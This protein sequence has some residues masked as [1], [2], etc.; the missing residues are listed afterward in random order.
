MDF[1]TALTYR[2]ACKVFDNTK[3]IDEALLDEIIE[4]GR[5]A[6]SSMG[7]QPWKFL[8]I[9][10]NELRSKLKKACWDQSQITDC[11]SLVVILARTTSL[12][13]NSEYTN[14]IIS[15]RFDKNKSEQ[16]AYRLRYSNF[17]ENNVG[18]SQKEL[19]AW[20]KAQC[21][22]SAYS[23]MMQASVSGIDSCPIEGFWPNVVKDILDI[24]DTEFEV[25]L[26]IC[27]GYRKNIQP[28]K[29]RL[30]K[31]EIFTAIN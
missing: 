8:L 21:F 27:F 14:N 4:A 1:K 12:L 23:M 22:L 24:T 3:Y 30:S 7:M 28:K 26:I 9:N 25:A 11:S 15:Q 16:E 31:D 13:P 29:F 17:I 19:F 10:N 2:H 6:P 20:S 18:T 5:L